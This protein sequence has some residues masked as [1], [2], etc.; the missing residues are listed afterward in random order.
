MTSGGSLICPD[1]QQPIRAGQA[2]HF[3]PNGWRMQKRKVPVCR[4]CYELSM[5]RYTRGRSDEG[6]P[7][8]EWTD[9]GRRISSRRYRHYRES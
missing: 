9:N 2:Y 1:C 8:S 7:L 5:V 4:N 6:A 3:S